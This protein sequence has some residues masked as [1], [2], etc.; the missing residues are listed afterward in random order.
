MK[1]IALIVEGKGD[2]KSI[3]SLIA[4]SAAAF[5]LQLVASDPPIRAG[6]AKKL[7]RT[8]ELE[9]YLRLAA[10]RDE[11]EEIILVVDLD[12]GCAKEFADEF[13]GRAKPIA[14]ETGK[15]IHICFCIR[16]YEAWLLGE[17]ASIAQALP[18]YGIAPGSVIENHS[19]IRGAK[20]RLS[21]ACTSK[22]YRQIRDQLLFTQKINVHKLGLVDRSF[23]K[24][25]KSI[26][27]LSYSDIVEACDGHLQA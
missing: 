18:E 9:R 12:D 11:A 23:R 22:K 24:L 25:L 8:G 20:E 4:K 13:N 7:R 26:T 1:K 17:L 10:T 14:D 21:K 3:P 6:E 2:V 5:G 27:S 16:E 15:S 19:S